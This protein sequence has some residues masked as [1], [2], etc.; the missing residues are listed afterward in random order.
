M[1]SGGCVAEL[2]AFL[3]EEELNTVLHQH[4]LGR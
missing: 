2:C 1:A 3:S 4:L